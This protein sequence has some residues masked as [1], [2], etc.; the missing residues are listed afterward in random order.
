MVV[1]LSVKVMGVMARSFHFCR[2]FAAGTAFFVA[3]MPPQG[4]F[5]FFHRLL[6]LSG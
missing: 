4:V 3:K 6:L 5:A 2:R 1:R